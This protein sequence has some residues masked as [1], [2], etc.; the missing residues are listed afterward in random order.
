LFV[1]F[2]SSSITFGLH[3]ADQIQQLSTLQCVSKALY[4]QDGTRMPM[5]FGVL[6]RKL[7]SLIQVLIYMLK[8]ILRRLHY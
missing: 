4:N 8:I 5:Q 2:P 3:S 6:D 7:V 1:N